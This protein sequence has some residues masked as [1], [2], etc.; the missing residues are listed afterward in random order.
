MILKDRRFLS[1]DDKHFKVVIFRNLALHQLYEA[2]NVALS[3]EKRR[4]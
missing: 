2:N 4:C 1:F 3:L